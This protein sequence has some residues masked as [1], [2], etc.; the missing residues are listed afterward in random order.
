MTGLIIAI[1]AVG[2][3]IAFFVAASQRGNW[4]TG[5]EDPYGDTDYHVPVLVTFGWP[6]PVAVAA[7][8]IVPFLLFV[9]FMAALDRVS[10]WLSV[11]AR[12]AR[13]KKKADAETAQRKVSAGMYAAAKESRERA[14]ASQKHFVQEGYRVPAPCP[15]VACGSPT[16]LDQSDVKEAMEAADIL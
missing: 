13:A 11:S 15:C 1:Y 10:D 7:V 14:R 8:F 9:G 5:K 3:V 16:S 4:W 12:E 6:V 2:T